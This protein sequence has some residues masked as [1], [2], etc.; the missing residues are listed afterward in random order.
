MTFQTRPSAFIGR[1]VSVKFGA[2]ESLREEAG[3]VLDVLYAITGYEGCI[4]ERLTVVVELDSGRFVNCAVNRLTAEQ[5]PSQ[6][7]ELEHNR[8]AYVAE[9][10]ARHVAGEHVLAHPDC[11][12]CRKAAGV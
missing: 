2:G 10:T 12:V 4:D 7:A 11:G 5:T 9:L 3:T 6:A 8:S 1:R